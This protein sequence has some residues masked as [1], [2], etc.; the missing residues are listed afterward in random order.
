MPSEVPT[1]GWD[2]E[3][4]ID[5]GEGQ[6]IISELSP[7][8]NDSP[9][10][11]LSPRSELKGKTNMA[12]IPAMVPLQTFQMSSPAYSFD[13]ALPRAAA[14]VLECEVGPGERS[15]LRDAIEGRT[16]GVSE[17]GRRAIEG[18]AEGQRASDGRMDAG[19]MERVSV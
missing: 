18:G 12:V 1:R 2:A 5:E 14:V 8:Y 15:T 7:K 19:I 4:I 3:I 16:P 17:A 10:C 9:A 13:R 6:Y 11:P